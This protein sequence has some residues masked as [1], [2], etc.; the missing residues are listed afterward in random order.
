MATNF[1]WTSTLQRR[2]L[3]GVGDS[4]SRLAIQ[5]GSVAKEYAM[6]TH[7]DIEETF[8]H[9]SREVTVR[10]LNRHQTTHSITV[11]IDHMLEHRILEDN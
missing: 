11:W 8:N 1:M 10:T 4:P 7:M 3:N 5:R 6:A 9:T 2:S